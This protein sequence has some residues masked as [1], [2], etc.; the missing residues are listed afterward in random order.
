M[1]ILWKVLLILL[2][3][4]VVLIIGVVVLFFVASKQPVVKE[5]YFEK[6][7]TN[8]P[9]EQKYTAKGE[10]SV[11]SVTFKTD[12][13]KIAQFKV[14]YP[15][16]MENTDNTYPLVV[17]A[18]GTGVKASK[19]EAIFDHLASWGFIVI[20][21]EDASSWDGVSSSESLKLM[22]HL[23]QD[24]TST[25]YGKIDLENIGVAGHSQGGVGAINAI[26]EHENGR[27]YK[28]IYTAST[29]HIALAHG[30]QWTYDVSKISIPYFMVAGTM[31]MDAGDGVEGSSN[32][33]IAPL[34]SL[35]E[36]YAAI[37]DGVEKVMARRVN[38][39]HGDM[40]QYADGYMT[41]WMM[42]QLKGD[43]DAAKVFIGKDAE[44]LVNANWQDVEINN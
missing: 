2:A 11:S 33:G 37:P 12:N 23:N 5:A 36:N 14:W 43:A 22:L 28:T 13:E 30:L 21:N 34:F 41:A 29:T 9:L 35:Q 4:I 17:M 6:V 15:T 27:Y 42:Y 18:N 3:V 31:K 38:T 10:Y 39:D 44:I 8:M 40:L 7:T 19:Y 1:R 32:V 24:N 26:T 16:E 25:F 20:G